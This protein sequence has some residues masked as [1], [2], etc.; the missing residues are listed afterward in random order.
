LKEEEAAVGREPKAEETDRLA[1]LSST[2]LGVPLWHRDI[3]VTPQLPQRW[4]QEDIRKE[5]W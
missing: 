3:G 5:K 2:C 1:G 4:P